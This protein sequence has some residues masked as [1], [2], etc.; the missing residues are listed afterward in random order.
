M[1]EWVETKD[2]HWAQVAPGTAIEKAAP[3]RQPGT[4]D[5]NA[6]LNQ[7]TNLTGTS[8]FDFSP[9]P[10]D[11][12]TEGQFNPGLPF[13]P[14]PLDRPRPEGRTDPR[15]YQYP[16]AWNLDLT[17]AP[18]IPFKTLRDASR[19]I[20]MVRRCIELRKKEITSREWSFG[21]ST[22][23]VNREAL[24]S[25][26]TPKQDIRARLMKD[27]AD[28]IARLEDFWSHPGRNQDFD[29]EAW[30]FAALEEYLSIDAWVIYPQK[31]LGGEVISLDLVD[32]TTIKPLLDDRG[33]KPSWP[34][35]AFQQMLY[36]FPRGEYAATFELLQ[37]G[38]KVVP[39]G[40]M[41]DQLYYIRRHS[42]VDS[43]YGMSAVEQAL[44]SARL[45]LKRQGW[46]LSEYDD[47]TVPMA[48]IESMLENGAIEMDAHQ[49]RMWEDALNDELSGN[50]AARHRLK[51]LPPGMKA[52]ETS[53]VDERYKPDYDLFLIKLLASHFDVP[54]T[55]LGFSEAR[56]LGSSGWHEGQ[57]DS[58]ERT[59]TLPDTRWFSRQ[60]T[61]ISR[62]QLGCPDILEHQFLGLD[63]EDEAAQD[64]VWENR[65]RSGRATLNEDRARLNLPLYDFEEADEPM[66][67]TTRGAVFLRGA[68]DLAPGG[69]MIEPVEYEPTSPGQEMDPATGQ[70]V[71][72]KPAAGAPQKVNPKI[73]RGETS[74]NAVRAEVD[75]Y[76][77]WARKH[78]NPTRPFEFKHATP[79]DLPELADDP[80]VIWS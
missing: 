5:F 50:T 56:G 69:T 13:L 38:E 1:P 76:R 75:A 72:P 74:I 78:P 59:A 80:R 9:L 71:K 58:H 39:S 55:E 45:Y 51:V 70:S 33:A 32:G 61:R 28:E 68:K 20:D 64:D 29:W 18:H 19:N 37:T 42:R 65:V 47:G 27:H 73:L 54:I 41:R 62:E 53:S 8:P 48:W 26:G 11:G 14:R 22:K 67:L 25:P 35:P 4:R 21:I 79:E 6:L 31:T 30:V 49:R 60:V 2:G 66:L 43:P 40:F 12:F 63:Q 36:G 46:M 77:K 23:A 52:Q 44:I 24:K 15:I 57:A 10:R 3:M 7:L 34:H 17:P 16:V